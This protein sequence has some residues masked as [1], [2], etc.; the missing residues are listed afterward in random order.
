LESQGL[1]SQKYFIPST[2]SS[3]TREYKCY[4]VTKMGCELLGNKQQGEKGI[5][6][7]AKYVERF[8]QMEQALNNQPKLPQTYKEALIELLAQVEENERLQIENKKL[9]EANEVLEIEVTHKE[10]VIIGLVQDIDLAEKRQRITQ[11]I[12]KGHTNY[13]ERYSLLYQEFEKKFHLDI[14]RRLKNGKDK[15]KIKKSVNKMEYICSEKYL[16]MCNDLY[17]ICCKL[18]EN[19]LQTLLEEIKEGVE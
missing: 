3:G 4:L 11:I 18:F 7:T 8:N 14:N 1:D 15:G 6:F 10:D 16:N 9:G 12:R 13:Q 19:D 17:D 5:L 2:Y